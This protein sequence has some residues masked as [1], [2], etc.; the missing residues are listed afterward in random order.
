MISTLQTFSSYN[1]VSDIDYQSWYSEITSLPYFLQKIPQEL[2]IDTYMRLYWLTEDDDFITREYN[3]ILHFMQTLIIPTLPNISNQD[4][5]RYL[6]TLNFSRWEL[7]WNTTWPNFTLSLVQELTNRIQKNIIWKDKYLSYIDPIVK[8][9]TYIMDHNKRAEEIYTSIWSFSDDDISRWEDLRDNIFYTLFNCTKVY[10]KEILTQLPDILDGYKNDTLKIMSINDGP[11]Q[12]EN[13]E[14]GSLYGI[15]KYHT[16][17]RYQIRDLKIFL[18]YH[19]LLDEYWYTA[20]H[21]E[22]HI[23]IDEETDLWFDQEK[24]SYQKPRRREEK[25]DNIVKYYLQFPNYCPPEKV[26]FLANFAWSS[27]E[28]ESFH[29]GFVKEMKNTIETNKK[30]RHRYSNEY[31]MYTTFMSTKLNVLKSFVKLFNITSLNELSKIIVWYFSKYDLYFLKYIKEPE[32]LD[33]LKQYTDKDNIP[34]YYKLSTTLALLWFFDIHNNYNSFG[35]KK[36][37]IK[38]LD[39]DIVNK[40]LSFPSP[41]FR[42]EENERNQLL[43]YINE[44]EYEEAKKFLFNIMDKRIKYS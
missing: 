7:R 12:L 4:L 18:K 23:S 1:S 9:N 42:P 36:E 22:K 13:G 32:K 26:F 38:W 27:K 39:Q 44:W 35:V 40:I 14:Y 43:E 33:I 8:M 6:G 10:E 34:A 30:G 19:H 2:H 5:L 29:N 15:K 28:F 11:I 31:E 17:K 41:Y 37:H 25:H 20:S 16:M 21:M 24:V 3:K